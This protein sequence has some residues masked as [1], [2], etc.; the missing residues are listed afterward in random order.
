MAEL[1]GTAYVRIRAITAGLGKDISDGIDKGVKDAGPDIDKS[2]QEV[3]DRMGEGAGK[4]FGDRFGDDVSDGLDSPEIKKAAEKSGGDTSKSYRKGVEDENKRKNPF[5]SFAQSLSKLGSSL[6]MPRIAWGA[7]F[8]PQI[9]GGIA[10]AIGAALAGVT[11]ALGFL[12][13]A[14]AGAG[15]ALGGIAAAAIPGLGVLV[16]ALKANTEEMAA[17]KKEAADLAEP[18][19]DVARAT[20]RTLLPGLLDAMSTMTHLIPLFAEFGEVIGQIGGDFARMAAA[21][22]VSE[23]NM[24]ALG[25]I[26]EDSTG[27]FTEMQAAGLA[28]VDTIL[29][30]FAEMT[31]LATQFAASLRGMAERFRDFVVAGFESGTLGDTF[32]TWYDRLAQV[33]R[34]LADLAVGLWNVFSVG[35][36]ASTNLF[37]SIEKTAQAFR[38]WTSS[39][40]GK[41]R[42][43]QWFEDAKP[44]MHEVLAA[45]ERH[46]RDRHRTHPRRRHGGHR[47]VRPQH[48]RELAAGLRAARR[49]PVGPRTRRRPR[50]TGRRLRLRDR[51][52]VG[53]R[54]LRHADRKPGPDPR[55][56]RPD[57]GRTARR[58]RSR[59]S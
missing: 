37:D 23:R 43:A 1:I 27:F 13:T 33:G 45:A 55:N 36:D 32:Q 31:P 48:P 21:T 53:V 4:G 17:F 2:G 50:P 30:L 19:I 29:P 5:A 34:I 49:R 10:S 9:L 46:R 16:A 6:K 40:E 52:H 42:L 51:R 20:Q 38:D 58:A 24:N 39:I 25:R 12:V 22:L 47:S 15:V 35:A 41:N 44:L 28:V 18:W 11:S 56:A 57:P 3:G 8:S 7:L 14:A 26:L 54:H 59:R